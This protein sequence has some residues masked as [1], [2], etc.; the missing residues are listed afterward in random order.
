MPKDRP[1]QGR[2]AVPAEESRSSSQAANLADL[3]A[4]VARQPGFSDVVAAIRRGDSGTI[5][6]AWGSSNAAAVA[7]LAGSLDRPLLIVVPRLASV[8]DFVADLSSFLG[9]AEGLQPLL[10]PAWESP[11]REMSATDPIMGRRLKMLEA[12]ESDTPPRLVVAP[13]AALMQPVP[14]KPARLD[15]VRTLR[16][17]D[18]LEPE[19]FMR[20]LIARSFERVAAIDR[21]GEFSMHGGILDLWSADAPEPY[22]IEF[23]GDEIESIRSFDSETQRKIGELTEVRLI[24]AAVGGQSS[25]VGDQRSETATTDLRP[26]ASVLDSLSLSAAVVLLEPTEIVDEGRHYLSRLDEPAGLFGVEAV[27]A[28]IIERPSVSV[29]SLGVDSYET[30]CRLHVESVERFSGPKQ[31]LAELAAALGRDEHVL[32]ACHNEGERERLR[33]LIE[34]GGWRIED[35]RSTKDNGSVPTSPSSLLNRITLCL[36]RVTKGFRLVAEHLIVLSDHELFGRTEVLRKP[37]KPKH[38]SRA[39]ETFLDLNE[40]DLIVHLVNGV[41]RFRGMKLL[42]KGEQKE[43]HLELEFAE[44]LRVFVPVSLIHLVQKY[45]G[46][47][48]A[49]PPLSKLGTATWANKKRRVAEAVQD[50]ASDMLR[51][52]AARESKP[53]IAYP[54][55]SHYVEEFDAAFPYEETPDQATAIEAVKEDMQRPRPMDRLIC[56]DVGYGKTEVAMRAAFK[57]VDAGKQV[58]ILV[59]TTVLAEQ[60]DRSFASRMAEFPV[61][62]ASLSRFKTKGEQ[63]KTVEKLTRGEVDI[64]IGTHRLVQQDVSFK[65]LGLLVIDEEQRFGVDVKEALKKLRLEVDV[66]TLSATPIP[67]TL[68]MAL[69]GIRDIS[70]LTTP[71][72]D[73]QSIETRISRWDATLIRHAIVRELNRG[74]QIYFVHNRVNDIHIVRDKVQ[75]IVPEASI[76]IVHGQM[77]GDELE[78]TMTAFVRGDIDILLATTIIESGLDIPNANTIFIHQADRYGLADLHQLR[79]R[80]GRYKHRAHCYLLLE[81]GKPLTDQAAKRLKA[82]EEFSELGAGFKIAMRDLEIRGAGNI[83]GSEQSGHITTVG[84]ELYC[85]L[86]E[87]A[88]RQLKGEPAREPLTVNIDLP[89][90]AFFPNAYVPPGRVKIELYRRLSNVRSFEEL[91]QL[92]EELRDRFGPPPAPAGRLLEV[93]EVQLLCRNWQIDEVRLEE[94]RFAVFSYKDGPK[95]RSLAKRVGS[96]FRVVDGRSAYYVLPDAAATNEA[97][98]SD[99]RNVLTGQVASPPSPTGRTVNPPSSAATRRA[100]ARRA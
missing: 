24:V 56:G 60:H 79:G 83:L 55:D 43:E 77:G 44:G 59:P 81:E 94:N 74:G 26:P 66:L 85:Q 4:L 17:G 15:A 28:K 93:K 10:I 87:N 86:L 97:L 82:I 46:A 29:T 76:G 2:G 38:E 19:A 1:K 63:K 18:E 27:L 23:F 53:G 73:R 21:P 95:I 71:P 45:V 99:L 49:A 88:V 32:L 65:D 57:A 98:L 92:R 68:H 7:A 12:L 48:K 91:N 58:A 16:V 13:L 41:G 33:E 40:G 62:T 90:S 8:D 52:H 72:R 75:A 22:R 9:E 20:W 51:L 30:T 31:A 36:G 3:P 47:T 35:G 50:L 14:P 54:P 80:V 89:I 78:E 64:V 69:L 96:D 42:E 100:A 39:I 61:V 34:D 11:P 5:D 70:N 25:E 84:Y 37:R 6:G 67:R